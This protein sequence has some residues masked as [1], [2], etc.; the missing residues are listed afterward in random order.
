MTTHA[1]RTAPP[2]YPI[3]LPER[4][5]YVV[6]FV[7]AALYATVLASLPVDAF[8][9]RANYL[10]YADYSDLIL[11]R[12]VLDG[13]LTIISNEPVWLAL[14]A[15]LA[16][17][18]DPYAVVRLLI[19]AAAFVTSFLVLKREKPQLLWIIL[20]LLFPPVIKNYIIHLRQGVAVALF[21]TGYFS[22]NKRVGM[23]LMALTPFI[24]SSFFF[25]LMIQIMTV[26]SRRINFPVW[27]RVLVFVSFFIFLGLT[28]GAVSSSLGARQANEYQNV[29]IGVS[30]LA[31]LF[32]LS[33]LGLF[34]AE[35]R[36]YI[37]SHMFSILLLS[38][39][40]SVYFFTVVSGRIFESG[41]LFVLLSGLYLS[42]LRRTAF[43]FIITIFSI[44]SYVTHINE[45]WL[46]WGI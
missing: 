10:A 2:A 13:W 16:T 17:A 18:L 19:F 21:L 5:P 38:F 15:A 4:H 12:Y 36:D 24:H 42:G 7:L 31:F 22:S 43:I 40:L 29:D 23:V 6:P 45:P 41:I 3:A 8:Q 27:A 46:G 28:L 33:I 1:P 9:D 11:L 44:T 14:N 26:A 25:I 20:F 39:Y 37:N 35:G 34:L 32:W 30:G